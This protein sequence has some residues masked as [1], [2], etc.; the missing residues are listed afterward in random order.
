[1]IVLSPD[2]F[3]ARMGTYD[4]Q[5]RAQFGPQ[6]TYALAEWAGAKMI[7]EWLLG[8][9]AYRSLRFEGTDGV[10]IVVVT[11]AGADDDPVRR[12]RRNS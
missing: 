3:W 5:L 11:A 12:E 1:M 7:D 2:E 8:D 4:D 9:G 6:R 10:Q